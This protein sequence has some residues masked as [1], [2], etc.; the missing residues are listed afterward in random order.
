MR[1]VIGYLN[2]ACLGSIARHQIVRDVHYEIDFDEFFDTVLPSFK[3]LFVFF[4]Q[5]FLVL[6]DK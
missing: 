2:F 5:F 4:T 6:S 3:E 1:M